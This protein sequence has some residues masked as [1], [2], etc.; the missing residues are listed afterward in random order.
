MTPN[1]EPRLAIR[2]SV[3]GLLAGA[4]FLATAV[5]AQ[6]LGDVARQEQARRKGVASAGKVYT[7]QSLPN[8]PPGAPAPQP[9]A[10]TGTPGPSATG[11]QGQTPAAGDQPAAAGAA[12]K[13]TKDEAYWRQRI[14]TERELL[15]RAQ[16]FADALQS[17]INALSTDFVNR[18]DPAQRNAIAADR[19]KALTEL[20]RVKKEIRDHTKAVEDIRQEARREG[21]P[22]GWVR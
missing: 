9:A 5:S 18:D 22:A 17:R 19:Q 10:Q 13:T 14:Q 2:F 11:S 4:L 1:L 16:S 8:T 12:D 21:V 20:D 15:A 6:S 7:N 3:A